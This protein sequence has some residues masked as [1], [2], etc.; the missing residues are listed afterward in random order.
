MYLHFASV[1]LRLV[2]RTYVQFRRPT[3]VLTKKVQY[4]VVTA[5]I[6]F[7]LKCFY[8]SSLH[9][10]NILLI[11]DKI[12]LRMMSSRSMIYRCH[13]GSERWSRFRALRVAKQKAIRGGDPILI[14]FTFACCQQWSRDS[15]VIALEPL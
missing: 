12:G 2:T 14:Q 7:P 3:C 8:C 4:K 13:F 1:W 9:R 10:N 15:Y 6:R 11:L 5:K